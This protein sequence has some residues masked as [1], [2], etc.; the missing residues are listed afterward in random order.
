[1]QELGHIQMPRMKDRSLCTDLLP[2]IIMVHYE[3]VAADE[4]P[5]DV[6]SSWHLYAFKLMDVCS[7]WL[8]IP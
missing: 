7:L 5:E 8:H 2:C 1:M 6:I 4:W 3:A